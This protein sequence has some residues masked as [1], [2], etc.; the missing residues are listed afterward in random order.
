MS[1]RRSTP[2]TI[3]RQGL[4]V[5][6]DTT[7]CGR[8][9][10]R[11]RANRTI[12]G[13]GGANQFQTGMR[14]AIRFA[15]S[16]W[17]RIPMTHRA[18]IL[19]TLVCW[20]ASSRVQ[21]EGLAGFP[22]ESRSRSEAAAG[23][24][25]LPATD[26]Q[27]D[28]A[29]ARVE[30][31]LAQVRR[32]LSVL[33]ELAVGSTRAGSD[34]LKQGA[35][36]FQQ[37]I[38]ALDQHARYLRKLKELRRTEGKGAVEGV[39]GIA[40]SLTAAAAEQ[41][42]DS[43]ATKNLELRREQMLLSIL[44]AEIARATGRLNES[45][46]QERLLADQSEPWAAAAPALDDAPLQSARAQI[47]A[48]EA[49]L[50]TS[51]IGRLV[52]WEAIEKL[53]RQIQSLE[54]RRAAV[55]AA[56]RMTRADLDNLLDQIKEKEARLQQELNDAIAADNQLRTARDTMA[57]SE[58]SA[59]SPVG[60]ET[61]LAFQIAEARVETSGQK[62]D[63]LRSFLRLA[64][65]ARTVWQDRFWAATDREVRPLRAKQRACAGAIH[66]LREWRALMEQSLSSVSEQVLRQ[67][68]RVE[69]RRLSPGES[70]AARQICATLQE[71]AWIQLR[72]VGG[73]AFAEDLSGRLLQELSEQVAK[74]STGGQLKAIAQSVGAA[75]RRVWDTEL[76]IAEDSAIAG[77][78]KVS[79][80]R[81]ITLGKVTIA[82]A[83][84]LCGLLAA[85]TAARFM[86]RFA[87]RW[88]GTTGR[89]GYLPAM[90]MSV[91]LAVA[92]L[93]VAMA[94]VRIPWTV[95]AFLGGALAI[96]VGFGAQTLINNFISG[97]ILFCERSI[98]VGDIV[99]VDGQRGKVARIGFRN[100][101]MSRGD[102][103]EVLVPN[104]QFLDKKVV[105]WTLTHDLVRYSISLRVGHY[106]PPERVTALM[107]QA[108]L[109]HSLVV[110]NPAPDVLL[111]DFGEN[112]LL[113]SLHFWMHLC[114]GSDGGRVRS[115]L[116]HR[117]HALFAEAGISMA[118]P[119]RTIHLDSL[120]PLEINLANGLGRHGEFGR[121]SG[122]AVLRRDY[123]R[124]EQAGADSFPRAVDE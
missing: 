35:E 49:S 53:R 108:A 109:E 51:E 103:I 14:L 100:S 121:S 123:G 85:R 87:A 76:Y 11:R 71:R 25:V 8:R 17:V 120:H 24:T 94:S 81:S 55:R 9:K 115:E 41:L 37:W 12:G 48:D 36:P 20:A 13:R 89:A 124:L 75:C 67:T 32:R 112:A 102:G 78:Q 106:T 61:A 68:L 111:E 90:M 46:R 88:T 22:T 30:K 39:A 69:D 15:A 28:A 5:L 19:F 56:T 18:V 57:R 3:V 105:N 2:P 101:L 38:V 43:L 79:V 93:G 21:A 73:L 40:T 91:V 96:G 95:F 83:I 31:R 26:E 52:T 72:I 34:S 47:Q 77:G 10:P 1:H 50:A 54:Q 29:L 33:S 23:P 42:T 104:S 122:N 86:T 74:A 119:E 113:F 7:T 65:Y 16:A 92:S 99:E 6:R 59:D 116:R 80:P 118:L 66:G 98:R 58:T 60:G 97:I 4:L 62:V 64:E 117:I 27:I 82:L 84:F 63:A 44:E 107:S 70:E 45:A 110:K 114:P